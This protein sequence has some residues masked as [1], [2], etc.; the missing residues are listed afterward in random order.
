MHADS[1]RVSVVIPTTGRTSVDHCLTS[2]KRQTRPADELVIIED[3]QRRGAPWSRNQGIQKCSGDLIAFI[4]DDCVAPAN[5]LERL[6]GAIDTYGVAGAGGTMT[7]SDPFLQAIRDRRDLPHAEGFDTLGIVGNTAN[8]IFEHQW[9][10]RCQVEDGHVFNERFGRFGSEDHELVLRIRSRG[11]R[12][13]YVANPVRHLRRVSL[14]HYLHYTFQRGIGIA[15]LHEA[16]R[17]Y[18]RHHQQQQSLLW[19]A[20]K[21]RWQRIVETLYGKFIG[22]TDV[23]AF[24]QT[25]YF[26]AF[27][28]SQKYQALGY[29]I[30]RLFLVKGLRQHYQSGPQ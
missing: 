10:N 3:R 26:V 21:T 30:G 13:A 19:S 5:W 23:G 28:L 24:P 7:D 4:D 9:L 25:K 18:G 29:I 20:T 8:I 27:W 12:M 6:I 22:P 11:G 1:H 14:P 17:R 15:L 16:H 2:L